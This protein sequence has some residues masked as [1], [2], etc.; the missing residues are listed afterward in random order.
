MKNK[1]NSIHKQLKDIKKLVPFDPKKDTIDNSEEQKPK[2]TK[3]KLFTQ[4][5]YIYYY[6]MSTPQE[7]VIE[8]DKKSISLNDL[9]SLE[10]L[11]MLHL[12]VEHLLL[13]NLKILVKYLQN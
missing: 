7:K 5:K 13:K 11:L 8:D 9:A 1:Q 4:K 10:I 12:D 6:K 2:P 3:K